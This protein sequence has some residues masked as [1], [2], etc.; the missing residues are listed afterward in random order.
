MKNTMSLEKLDKKVGGTPER[1]ERYYRSSEVELQRRHGTESIFESKSFN[2]GND[3]I[4]D[5]DDEQELSGQLFE[6]GVDKAY[7]EEDEDSLEERE[8]EGLE[9]GAPE[10]REFQLSRQ[11]FSATI[12]D[13]LMVDDDNL[14]E[15]PKNL[16]LRA[17]RAL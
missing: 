12:P 3:F 17:E 6:A 1:K 4:D 16:P 15:I 8:I 7:D 11:A 9:E 13:E 2:T 5:L 14:D 10:D